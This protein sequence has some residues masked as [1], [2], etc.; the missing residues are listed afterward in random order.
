VRRL[1]GRLFDP[2]DGADGVPVALVSE[3]LAQR[4][5]PGADPL[6]QY[7]KPGAPDAAGPWRE[8]VG[9]VEDVTQY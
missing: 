8:M 4:L 6:G 9:I 1:A 3:S 7:V 5:W 2:R